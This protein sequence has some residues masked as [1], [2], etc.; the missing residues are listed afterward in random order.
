MEFSGDSLDAILFKLYG[1]L[2]ANGQLHVGSRGKTRELISVILHI[3]RPRARV[4]ISEN[5]GKFFSALR[6]VVS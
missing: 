2:E 1:A 4:S 6:R 5:R 3:K